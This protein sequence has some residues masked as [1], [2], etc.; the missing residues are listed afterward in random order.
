MIF[1]QVLMEYLSTQKVCGTWEGIS[2]DGCLEYNKHLS[3]LSSI[4]RIL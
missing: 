1:L 2:L 3:F 4:D